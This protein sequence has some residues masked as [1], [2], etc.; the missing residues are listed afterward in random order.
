LDLL[1]FWSV[2]KSYLCNMI[3]SHDFG[4]LLNLVERRIST[5]IKKSKFEHL[6]FFLNY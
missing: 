3:I 2:L 1:L 4:N 6:L 5:I